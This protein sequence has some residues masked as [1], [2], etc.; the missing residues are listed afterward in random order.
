MQ[1]SNIL[2]LFCLV[3][4]SF[5]IEM[6]EKKVHLSTDPPPMLA[7]GKINAEV[8]D[9]LIALSWR[10]VN[11]KVNKESNELY[12]SMPIKIIKATSQ[13]VAGV[14]YELE[15]LVGESDCAKNTVS[16]EQVSATRCSLKETSTAPKKVCKF[17]VWQKSWEN[18]EE[19]KMTGC[20]NFVENSN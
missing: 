5:A 18:F 3:L 12:H 9:E 16:H 2:V 15:V 13:V 4:G 19:I 1:T 7:G 20:E 10:A 17:T 11:E 14:S 8:D 6:E